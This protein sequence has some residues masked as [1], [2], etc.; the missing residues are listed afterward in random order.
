MLRPVASHDGVHH[1][2]FI[3]YPWDNLVAFPFLY[4]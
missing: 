4:S 2:H 3:K 1:H